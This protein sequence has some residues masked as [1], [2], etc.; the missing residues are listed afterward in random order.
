MVAALHSRAHCIKTRPYPLNDKCRVVNL[1]EKS[2][3]GTGKA[4][5][6]FTRRTM[7]ASPF[8]FPIV[9]KLRPRS[10]LLRASS[11]ESHLRGFR[12]SKKGRSM[13]RIFGA[14]ARRGREYL[15]F[16]ELAK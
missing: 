12:R 2:S 13:S 14:T 11:R 1:A 5:A 15:D 4:T 9:N 3:S 10:F 6:T 16:Y 7:N 8:C